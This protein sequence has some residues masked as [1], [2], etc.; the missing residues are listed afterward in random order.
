MIRIPYTVFRAVIDKIVPTATEDMLP[1]AASV[2]FDPN[3]IVGVS[4]VVPF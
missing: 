1:T 3:E 4:A 2:P